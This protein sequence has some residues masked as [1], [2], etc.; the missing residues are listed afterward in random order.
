[1]ETDRRGKWKESDGFTQL[2]CSFKGPRLGD[3]CFLLG[4]VGLFDVRVMNPSRNVVHLQSHWCSEDDSMRSFPGRSESFLLEFFNIY[5]VTRLVRNWI[6]MSSPD[7]RLD[8]VLYLL[9]RLQV[10]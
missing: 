6:G 9:E 4:F 10:L 3:P 8:D 2:R 5:Q 1:M 7:K